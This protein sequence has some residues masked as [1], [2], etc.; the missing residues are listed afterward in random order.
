MNK[1]KKHNGAILYLVGFVFLL[2]LATALIVG[3]LFWVLQAI[4]IDTETGFFGFVYLLIFSVIIGTLLAAVFGS[5]IT[6][7]FRLLCKATEKIASG[8]FAVRLDLQGPNEVKQLAD[9]FNKMAIEL[10]SVE[11]L[12]SD[13][14]NNVSHEFRTPVASIKGFAKLLKKDTISKE[15]R[16]EYLDIIIKESDRLAKLS[17]N[18][19]LMSK[20]EKQE[21]LSEKSSYLLDEQ[22]RQATLMLEPDWSRKEIDIITEL[23]TITYIGNEAL[24]MQVWINLIGNAIKF[25][26]CGGTVSI[27]LVQA[28]DATIVKIVDTGIGMSDETLKHIFD[29]FYQ[30]DESHSHEGNGLGLALVNRIVEMSNGNL[31]VES[32]L[33]KGTTVSVSLPNK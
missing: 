19:L 31:T 20:V 21:I 29:K 18:I 22:L 1:E 12:R 25:T 30:G 16:D 2:L 9:S 23:P 8:D 14:V 28:I 13:F 33:G 4:G 17:G 6:K 10:G 32:E 24:L 5:L 7:P 15:N 26:E 27:S 11:V 3:A